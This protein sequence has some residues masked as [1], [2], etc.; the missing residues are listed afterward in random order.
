MKTKEEILDLQNLIFNEKTIN[1]FLNNL[2][3][4]ENDCIEYTGHVRKNGYGTLK[5]GKRENY[6]DV[7]AHRFAFQLVIGGYILKE[8]I[9]VCH[10]CDNPTCVNPAHLFPGTNQDNI[11]DKVRK[12]RAPT[13]FGNA[14]IDWETVDEIRSSNLRNLDLA[15]NLNICKSTVSEIRNNKIWKEENRLKAIIPIK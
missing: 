13:I 4:G 10:H 12:G 9:Q 15:K 2:K 11:D 14:N 7:L 1:R 5:I 3:F 6:I 8:N